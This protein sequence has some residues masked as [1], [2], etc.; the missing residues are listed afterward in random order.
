MDTP[1]AG[2]SSDSDT[3][4]LGNEA[5][6]NVHS[7]SNAGIGILFALLVA[8]ALAAGYYVWKRKQ[9]DFEDEPESEE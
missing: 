6:S 9:E 1:L 2:P 8:A 4:A 5:T 3:S 7:K